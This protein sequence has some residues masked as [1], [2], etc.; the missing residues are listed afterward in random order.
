M[1]AEQKA[2]DAATRRRRDLDLAMTKLQQEQD[3]R[4]HGVVS[5]YLQAGRI[6]RYEVR[7]SEKFPGG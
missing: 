6:V 1:T 5:F 2:A 4:R 7:T 3:A